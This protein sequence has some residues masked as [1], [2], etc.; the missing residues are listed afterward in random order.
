[1]MGKCGLGG[2]TLLSVSVL[3]SSRSSVDW[4]AAFA[5]WPIQGP[6]HFPSC[7]S[8]VFIRSHTLLHSVGR[9]KRKGLEK[10]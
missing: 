4:Q 3:H 10:A 8:A 5:I 1:M 9:W 2:P 6:G 7:G